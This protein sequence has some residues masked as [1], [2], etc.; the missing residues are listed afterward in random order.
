MLGSTK[1]FQQWLVI[2]PALAIFM[3][4][5]SREEKTVTRLL[6]NSVIHV[7][8]RRTHHSP[9]WTGKC[10]RSEPAVILF[11]N[12]VCNFKSSESSYSSGYRRTSSWEVSLP[13]SPTEFPSPFFLGLLLFVFLQVCALLQLLHQCLLFLS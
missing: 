6:P 11:I 9:H 4:Q 3:K 12:S 2:D 13:L 7:R 10:S 8:A 1:T 5:L